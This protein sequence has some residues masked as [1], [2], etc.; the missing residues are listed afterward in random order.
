M[1]LNKVVITSN[2]T[3]TSYAFKRVGR[4]EYLNKL[5]TSDIEGWV[6][7]N[8]TCIGY[9]KA[10]QDN[11]IEKGDLLFWK[12]KTSEYM[13]REITE[14]GT[15][16]FQKVLTG[17]HFAVVEDLGL[18]SEC[19]RI[20]YAPFPTLQI[21]RVGDYRERKPTYVIKIPK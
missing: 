10:V 18:Y 20:A 7:E 16:L 15:L 12:P 9:E 17:F 4:Q 1:V 2:D 21:K 13:P 6:S 11:S 3:C 5:D 8:F 14:S 19:T